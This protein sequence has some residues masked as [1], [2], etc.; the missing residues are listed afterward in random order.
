MKITLNFIIIFN[1]FQ[2]SRILINNGVL[3]FFEFF[4]FFFIKPIA[5]IFLRVFVDKKTYFHP[6]ISGKPMI[7]LLISKKVKNRRF[8]ALN[9]TIFHRNNPLPLAGKPKGEL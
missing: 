2:I 7:L 6:I 4:Y 9:K 5:R 1:E 8:S 3:F